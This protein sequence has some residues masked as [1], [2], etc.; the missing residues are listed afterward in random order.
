MFFCL[1]LLSIGAAMDIQS[2]RISNRLVVSGLVLGFI[3]Q[4]LESG[5]KGAGVFLLNISIPVILF[6]LLFLIHALGAGDIKLFSMIGGIWGFQILCKT[7]AVSFLIGAAMSL[8]KLLCHRNLISRLLVL[9]GYVRQ[10]LNT[11]RLSEYPQEFQGNQ[12]V[13]HFS[14]AILIGY[15]I[16]MEV[17]Y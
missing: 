3:F 13:I 17:T 7:I 5:V 2:F 10:F 4:I 16:V 8:V 14:I 1:M 6:Y 11:G 15:A 12:H 9:K